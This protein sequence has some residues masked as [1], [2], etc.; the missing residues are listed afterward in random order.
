MKPGE[1]AGA[2]MSIMSDTKTIR[3]AGYGEYKG[4]EIPPKGIIFMGQDLHELNYTNPRID[5][6]NGHAIWG[7]QCWWGSETAIKD[8]IKLYEDNGYTVNIVDPSEY[9]MDG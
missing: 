4:D 6:D 5:L 3:L 9:S 8:K 2:V 7:C 1:R